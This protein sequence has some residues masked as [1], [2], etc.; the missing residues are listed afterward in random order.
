[1]IESGLDQLPKKPTELA[2]TLPVA[3]DRL[4]SLDH[5]SHLVLDFS[6]SGLLHF[7]EESDVCQGNR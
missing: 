7:W 2:T 3:S 6:L 5:P 1:M 4:A